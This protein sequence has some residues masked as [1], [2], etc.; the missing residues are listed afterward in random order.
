MVSGSKGIELIETPPLLGVLRSGVLG[1]MEIH[2]EIG[3]S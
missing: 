2:T 3:F 1:Y